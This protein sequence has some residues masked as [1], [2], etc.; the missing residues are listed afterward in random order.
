MAALSLLDIRVYHFVSRI[1]HINVRA[2]WEEVGWRELGITR[3]FL[4]RKRQSSQ[5]E[6]VDNL[7]QEFELR[8]FRQRWKFYETKVRMCIERVGWKERRFRVTRIW[9]Y[10]L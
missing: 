5:I 9:S 10:R 1:I 2:D 8:N 3:V 6:E 7:T 4:L